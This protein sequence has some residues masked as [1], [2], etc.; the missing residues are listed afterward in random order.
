MRHGGREEEKE[1]QEGVEKE[2]RQAT[3]QPSNQC[4][5]NIQYLPPQ[6]KNRRSTALPH[7]DQHNFSSELSGREFARI[8]SY[9]SY[10]AG[11][12]VEG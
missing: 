12:A 2:G 1:R 5:V 7:D 3:K 9:L 4:R 8:V 6:Y 10:A 11:A